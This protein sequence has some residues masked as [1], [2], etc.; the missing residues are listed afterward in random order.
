[1]KAG[2]NEKSPDRLHAHVLPCDLCIL[3]YKRMTNLSSK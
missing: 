3:T 2:I 1:M